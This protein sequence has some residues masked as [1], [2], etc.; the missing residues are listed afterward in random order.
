[1]KEKQADQIP[2]FSFLSFL[3]RERKEEWAYFFARR[4]DESAVLGCLVSNQ[5]CVQID[6]RRWD[7]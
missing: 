1:M 7:E 5:F 2:F 4:S 3:W 6:K